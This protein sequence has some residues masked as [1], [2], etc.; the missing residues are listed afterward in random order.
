MGRL[1]GRNNFKN[2]VHPLKTADPKA[3]KQKVKRQE[4]E[5]EKVAAPAGLPA[6]WTA[7]RFVVTE[8]KNKGKN[9]LRFNSADGKHRHCAT[10]TQAIKKDAADKGYDAQPLIEKYRQ[11]ATERSTK[12]QQELAK[13][14]A[15]EEK[16]VEAFRAKY[17]GA[18]EREMVG[19]LPGWTLDAR[20]VARTGQKLTVYKSLEGGL[21]FSK[22]KDVEA[23][24]GSMVLAGKDIPG[25]A[26]AREKA[27]QEREKGAGAGKGKKNRRKHVRKNKTTKASAMAVDKVERNKPKKTITK[28]KQK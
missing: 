13:S 23:K 6:G 26:Q 22:L 12:N 19:H 3:A 27:K 16:A 10:I 15:G 5:G 11:A 20:T 4:R 18:L 9:F 1:K 28:K 2:V 24:L 7:E 17:G 21:S 25:V 14:T 8:G